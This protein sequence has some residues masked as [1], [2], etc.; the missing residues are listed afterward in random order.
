MIVPVA[1]ATPAPPPSVSRSSFAVAEP[2]RPQ[3]QQVKIT[4]S[5]S[6]PSPNANQ[7]AQVRSSQQA[8]QPAGAVVDIAIVLTLCSGVVH[9][10][11]P[12]Q[13][14]PNQL[15]VLNDATARLTSYLPVPKD[16]V[17]V[18]S[19]NLREVGQFPVLGPMDAKRNKRVREDYTALYERLRPLQDG[20]RVLALDRRAHAPSL[21][22]PPALYLIGGAFS[23][24]VSI[25]Q[26]SAKHLDDVVAGVTRS[27]R[28]IATSINNGNKEEIR[29]QIG[30]GVCA[31]V[32]LLRCVCVRLLEIRAPQVGLEISLALLS[33]GKS[34]S[35]ILIHTQY[36]YISTQ[37]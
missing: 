32:H 27:I 16:T 11:L 14:T 21:V 12:E 19:Q 3:P 10:S 2:A 4:S 23:I 6:P 30:F 37:M 24:F 26:P 36:Y 15:Q 5:P 25:E 13:F 1:R 22:L 28:E 34:L 31:Y 29:K 18:V 8:P 17:R 35:G 33:V 7:Q 20:L 9:A